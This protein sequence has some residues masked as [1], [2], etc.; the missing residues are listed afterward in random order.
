MRNIEA[1]VK[2]AEETCISDA[3]TG[4]P[5]PPLSDA[6]TG[7][8]PPPL[9]DAVT[10][11]PPPPLSDAVTGTPPPPLSDAVTGSPPPPLSDAVTGSPPPPLSD[12][13]TGD[14][15]TGSPPPPLS[16]AVT[17]TPP[18]PLS[19]AVTG[20]PPP[21][22]SDAVTGSPPPPLSDAVTGSPPPPLS[23]AVTGSPP[24]PL[25]DAV[26][27]SPP[28]PLSDAV[29]GSPP[30]PLSDTVTGIKD[31]SPPQ[32][33]PRPDDVSW[34][35]PLQPPTSAGRGHCKPRRQLGGATGDLASA[36]R[37]HRRPNVSWAGPRGNRTS[38]RRGHGETGRQLGGAT[39]NLTSAGVAGSDDVRLRQQADGSSPAA[40]LCTIIMAGAALLHGYTRL[41]VSPALPQAQRI[42]LH[43]LRATA[44]L[45][46]PI[47]LAS[48]LAAG[49]VGC[50]SGKP[51]WQSHCGLHTSS[52]QANNKYN[53]LD[54]SKYTVRPIGVRKTGGRD[55]TGKIKV[56]GIGGGHKQRYRMIDFQRLRYQPGQ[57]ELPF[58]EKVVEVRYDPCR[59]ADIAL[60][61]GGSR[62]RWIIATENMEPGDILK[63]SG[64][65]GRMA[66]SANEGDAYP[67]GALPVGT[68]VN[69]LELYPG[70]GALYIRAA[71]TCG[72][73]LRKV[74]GTAIV[75]LPSKRQVQ[76]L[77]SCVA[78]V[79]R[80]S[81]IDHN[82]RVI[83]KA[84]RNRWLG[85]RPSSGLWQ[86]KGG[87]AGRKIRPL[88]PMKSY[89]NLPSP[90][91]VS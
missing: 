23:D 89:V 11:S 5:P 41:T 43:L 79:G 38:A 63:T 7:T 29:T 58:E 32:H 85:I 59:S 74:N 13:V 4:S 44:R 15:V 10:G 24:P 54:R 28:P 57:L 39:G 51:G 1:L 75:Q 69:S 49:T 36:G 8:P 25:S 31:G 82:K 2:K 81:N 80:V 90:G 65:I 50:S 34:A 60:I 48:S 62:K 67:L 68:L 30:P 21:P 87:W 83:G 84:G 55:H 9:S 61:A 46:E 76:V 72:V 26:T 45:W 40:K 20:T 22:L 3:V 86:R 19:D 56:H 16:D 71:G 91:T 64:Q 88:P 35:G 33:P 77:E 52:S 66:V 73:L 6:V 78:T 70:K 14:A 18:P 53:W 37:G 27:G 47:R 42:F 17:G 12:T